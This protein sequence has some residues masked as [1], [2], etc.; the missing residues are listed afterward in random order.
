MQV[1][2]GKPA[3]TMLA[4]LP[5]HHTLSWRALAYFLS[6]GGARIENRHA[7]S[8]GWVVRCRAEEAAQLDAWHDDVRTLAAMRRNAL[9]AFIGA[10]D[11]EL[12]PRGVANALLR[13]I[14][15]VLTDRP[16]SLHLPPPH[17]LP[18]GMRQWA[19][20]SQ[21]KWMWDPM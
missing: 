21:V 15:Y 11:V 13:E 5:F 4:N 8:S 3:H 7:V 12:H 19:N 1:V 2:G 14:A 10:L 16:T 17:V 20:M 18:T 9:A 6:A